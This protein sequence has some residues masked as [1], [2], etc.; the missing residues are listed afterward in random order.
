MVLGEDTL[1]EFNNRFGF[2]SLPKTLSVPVSM[3]FSP[4]LGL[5]HYELAESATGLGK[6]FRITPLNAAQIASAIA[7]DGVMMSPYLVDKLTNINGL[8][9][10]EN[11]PV[12]YRNTI[13]RPT[14]QFLTTM[15][16][17]DVER[18]IGVKARTKGIKIAGKTGTSGSRDPN[19]HAW[20][21]CF[22]PV[23]NPKIAMAILAEN[24][25]TGKD[26]AAPIAKKVFEGIMDF[27]DL[28]TETGKK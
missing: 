1:F 27:M 19:F 15:M 21:I 17:N 28:T 18:G 13:S 26:V 2:N 7:N 8:T 22:A 6:S 14:A 25:G 5:T 10:E 3:G 4:K 11:K 24:G 23:D 16:L 20:F 12:L 9:L